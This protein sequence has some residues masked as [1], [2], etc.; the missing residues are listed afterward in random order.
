VSSLDLE[1]TVRRK[2]ED[3]SEVQAFAYVSDEGLS[4]F[5][6]VLITRAFKPGQLVLD[7][8]CGG[9]R[10]AIPMARRGLRVVA[11]DL[12]PAMVRSA[13]RR[14]AEHGVRLLPI[15]G[16]ASA[17]PFRDGVFDGV[18]MLGQVI[19]H[20]P[21]RQRRISTLQRVRHMLKSRGTLAMTTHNRRCHLKFRLYFSV[22]NRWRALRRH[23][24][25]PT[26]LGDHD[27]WTTR[28]SRARS[29]RPVFFHM[30]DREEALTDLQQAGF[31]VLEAKGRTEF[32][33]EREDLVVRNRNYLLGFL[34]RPSEAGTQ[35]GRS[36]RLHE[37][38][39]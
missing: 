4:R 20:V 3:P 30:Y 6:E 31:D 21:E 27:R 19:A 15:V 39:T 32:E 38:G 12:V 10:E 17:P 34:A 18:A 36:G 5:E 11:M 16:S 1:A 37:L 24:G 26:A 23:L 13:A 8:G 2:Y 14:A 7:I 35:T 28:V 25:Y 9:G 33:A 29:S 22:V